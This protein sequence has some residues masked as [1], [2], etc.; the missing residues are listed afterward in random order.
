MAMPKAARVTRIGPGPDSSSS[1]PPRVD[2]VSLALKVT[3]LSAA[4]AS[5]V[6]AR[7]HRKPERGPDPVRPERPAVEVPL[8]PDAHSPFSK[9][10]GLCPGRLVARQY[11]VPARP[12]S[13]GTTGPLRRSCARAKTR[14]LSTRVAVPEKFLRENVFQPDVTA[15]GGLRFR[16]SRSGRQ[17]NWAIVRAARWEGRRIAATEH[18]PDI[19]AEP[20]IVVLA[21]FTADVETSRTRSGGAM[22]TGESAAHCRR[23]FLRLPGRKATPIP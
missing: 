1:R 20:A 5:P 15:C 11:S 23:T 21:W 12:P 7:P 17:V 2:S 18:A 13:S 16:H 14:R 19:Q 3:A 4:V 8:S 10:G 6:E 9:T 22:L